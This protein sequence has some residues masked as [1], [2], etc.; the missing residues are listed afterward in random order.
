MVIDKAT[1]SETALLYVNKSDEIS[2]QI[3]RKL[4]LTRNKTKLSKKEI[5]QI[6]LAERQAEVK[7]RQRTK[8]DELADRQR[9][10]EEK[11]QME[12]SASNSTA[13]DVPLESAAEKRKRE[14]LEKVEKA[15]AERERI[16]EQRLADLEKK[17]AEVLQKQEE[18]KVAREKARQDALNRKDELVKGSLSS[19]AT[20]NKKPI[21]DR[22]AQIKAQ[23]EMRKK[24]A[25]DKKAKTLEERKKII[26]ARKK[27]L[28]DAKKLR[29]K[30]IE[31]RKKQSEI[32]K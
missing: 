3:I 29:L 10:L 22:V 9:A 20:T 5:E 19:A 16:R 7:D 11:V 18:A 25:A 23:Q 15:K 6:E 28:E 17:K 31:E 12:Q 2:D 21:S 26:D 24:E 30:E 14:L 8:R 13:P 4:D 32:S 27:Q 1:S